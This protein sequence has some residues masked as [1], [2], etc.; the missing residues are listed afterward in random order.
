MQTISRSEPLAQSGQ[1]S[2]IPNKERASPDLLKLFIAT[3][4]SNR[5][6]LVRLAPILSL[7]TEKRHRRKLVFAGAALCCLVLGLIV[8]L[9]SHSNPAA[10][11]TPNSQQQT[12]A[13]PS[14]RSGSGM[15]NGPVPAPPAIVRQQ[16][17]APWV[18][19]LKKLFLEIDDSAATNQIFGGAPV[20][21]DRRSGYYF[22]ADSPYFEK[23]KPGSIMTQSSA[24]QSGYQPKL[25]AYCH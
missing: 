4:A 22:C 17:E 9:A 6:E 21:T 3:V 7:L 15:T 1:P 5:N 16:A 10:G 24:L 11:A 2:E 13:S 20:W 19:A 18:A 8:M 23:L 12:P 14:A 25:G